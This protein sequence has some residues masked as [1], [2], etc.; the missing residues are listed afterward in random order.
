MRPWSLRRLVPALPAL[1]AVVLTAATAAAGPIQVLPSSTVTY[2]HTSGFAGAAD[3]PPAVFGVP[4]TTSP[5]L[6]FTS[7]VPDPLSPGYSEAEGGVSGF[8]FPN[9]AAVYF[10]NRT[11]VLQSAPA[12]SAGSALLRVDFDVDFQIDALGFGPNLG[13]LYQI[14][15]IGHVGGPG[16]FARFQVHAEAFS[17]QEGLF[18]PSIDHQETFTAPGDF[19][20]V[21]GGFAFTT[22]SSLPPNDVV[23]I[24]G[25]MEFEARND[26]GPTEVRLGA[27]PNFFCPQTVPEPASLTL[28]GVAGCGLLAARVRG[29]RAGRPA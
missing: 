23:T 9:A 24:R 2:T 20:R 10:R 26:G 28:A 3:P 5:P 21:Y 16:S 29:R 17:Q 15:V 13:W 6:Q 7:T 12:G 1:A 8:A 19:S 11:G 4:S 14:G 18:S 25:F 27:P 22:P